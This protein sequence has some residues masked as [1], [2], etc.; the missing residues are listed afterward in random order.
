M[1][2]KHK[3]PCVINERRSE[4]SKNDQ[5]RF[6]GCDLSWGQPVGLGAIAALQ[7][8]FGRAPSWLRRLVSLSTAS[9]LCWQ[10]CSTTKRKK[11]TQNPSEVLS[12]FVFFSLPSAGGELRFVASTVQRNAE[13]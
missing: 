9:R 5:I 6:S 11:K 8:T 1:T 7:N 3:S 2:Q 13:G 10:G 4:R 12:F